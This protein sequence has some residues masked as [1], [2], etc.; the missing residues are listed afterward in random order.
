MPQD[1]EIRNE[2]GARLPSQNDALPHG[3]P[4]T[5]IEVDGIHGFLAEPSLP[6]PHP[7]LFLV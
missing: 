6:R 1:H 5:N 2:Y 7:T 4:Y 3:I